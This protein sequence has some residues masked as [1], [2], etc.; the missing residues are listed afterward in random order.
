MAASGEHQQQQQTQQVQ[1]V[2]L[3]HHGQLI[4]A[5]TTTTTDDVDDATAVGS[6]SE[7]VQLLHTTGGEVEVMGD[8]DD[9][10]CR[11]SGNNSSAAAVVIQC[12]DA[13]DI[14]EYV[15][16]I[17]V[18]IDPGDD[19]DDP[20]EY[21]A[22]VQSDREQE[23][24]VVLA[25]HNNTVK[26]VL[27][28]SVH[29][30]DHHHH[31][32]AVVVVSEKQEDEGT[33][34]TDGSVLR[35]LLQ[36]SCRQLML[37]Q[38]HMHRSEKPPRSIKSG[39]TY[40]GS[41]AL[42]RRQLRTSG[43]TDNRTVVTAEVDDEKVQAVVITAAVDDEVESR[44]AV[45]QIETVEPAPTTP[46]PEPVPTDQLSV[47]RRID[48]QIKALLMG[49]NYVR[50]GGEDVGAVDTRRRN[51]SVTHESSNVKRRRTLFI[52]S[53][54]Q[55]EERLLHPLF[56]E[57]LKVIAEFSDLNYSVQYGH[58]STFLEVRRKGL[59]GIPSPG[60]TPVQVIVS[61]DG[62]GQF[63]SV[64][65]GVMD[66]VDC[67]VRGPSESS[68]ADRL[69]P[70]LY[71]LSIKS[72]HV[73]CPGIEPEFADSVPSSILLGLC[74]VAGPPTSKRHRSKE[75]ELWHSLVRDQNHQS[76]WLALNEGVHKCRECRR[77]DADLRTI[78]MKVTRT[79]TTTASRDLAVKRGEMLPGAAAAAATIV[80]RTATA[81]D[82]HAH[83]HEFIYVWD[84]AEEMESL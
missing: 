49:H 52:H 54:E 75:C 60:Q 48:S 32:P 19:D 29:Q 74:H 79:T 51:A 8:E 30:D 14:E 66:E 44:A 26:K 3:H 64:T 81:V 34:S 73:Y 38:A 78:T 28:P 83:G 12:V 17:G 39:R 2:L 18:D 7:S 10:G 36:G 6:L 57:V 69:R 47:S 63:V 9:D 24:D 68:V 21:G 35:T 41:A 50:E 59:Y 53:S 76:N 55:D 27:L 23:A 5:T 71:K 62:I 40:S 82:V 4:G 13:T 77:L 16:C 15:E 43:S 25:C 65:G 11:T 56:T 42:R 67:E 70:L 80:E 72:G 46:S 45:A 61:D 58:R 20:A 33:S 84:T 31:R 22:A 37:Y 1:F